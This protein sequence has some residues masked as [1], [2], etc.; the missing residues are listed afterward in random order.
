DGY[1]LCRLLRSDSATASVPIVVATS[2][3]TVSSVQRAR[4]AGASAVLTKPFSIDPFIATI[5][6]VLESQT[7]GR[8]DDLPAT[9]SQEILER[10]A[11]T[12]SRMKARTHQRYVT[13]TP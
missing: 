11:R 6:E 4:A 1:A 12:G 3:A 10:A 2:E 9:P 13:A 7:P 5:R 8:A